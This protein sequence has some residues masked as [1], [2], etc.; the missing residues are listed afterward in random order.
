MS[1]GKISAETQYGDLTGNVSIDGYNS[2]EALIGFA[3][4]H[5]INIKEYLPISIRM[6]KEETYESILIYTIKQASISGSLDK[7]LDN[8]LGPIPVNIVQI[9]DA[10]FND[11]LNFIKRFD[12]VMVPFNK[13]IG[14]E[15]KLVE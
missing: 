4:K 1:D 13:V 12:L 5:G 8:N 14:R 2:D 9:E 15:Y 10:T 7:Y 3:E 11:Y 6:S